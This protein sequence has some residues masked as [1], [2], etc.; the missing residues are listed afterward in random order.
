MTKCP[1]TS[2]DLSGE[3]AELRRRVAELESLGKD[4]VD[5]EVKYRAMIEAFD[6]LIYICSQDYRIEF[7]NAHFIRR[8]GHD[9]TGELCYKALHNLDSVCSWCVNERV[10]KGETV[11]WEVQSP[12]DNR[13]F[14]VVNTPIYHADGRI[15]KQAMIQD[16]TERKLAEQELRE[17]RDHLAEL[18]KA[19]TA[20]LSFAKEEAEA[21]NR[22][23]SEFLANMS[24]ELRTPLNAIMGY[25]QILGM[26][27]NLTASQRDQ[28]SIIRSS[29]EQLLSLISDILDLSR[30]EAQKVEVEGKE[31][32]LLELI[33]AVLGT[34]RLRA[35]KKKLSL[36]Y[37]PLS[38][39]PRIVKGD[40]KKIRQILLNLLDNAVKYTETGGVTLRVFCSGLPLPVQEATHQD[41]ERVGPSEYG[42]PSVALREPGPARFT[43]QV[44]D[45]GIGI[46]KEKMEQIFEP[47]IQGKSDGRAVEGIGLGLAICRRLVDL[48][49]QRLSVESEPGRG[50]TFTVTLDLEVVERVKEPVRVPERAIIGYAGVSRRILVV[51]DNA[52]NLSMLVSALESLGFEVHSAQSGEQALEMAKE[53]KPD[54]M[55]LDFLMP[56]TDGR[57]VLRRIKAQDS[58]KDIKVIGI[59]AAVA[60]GHGAETFAAACDDF[61]SKPVEFRE[62]LEKMRRHLQIE[63]IEEGAEA[64]AIDASTR[65]PAT[66]ENKTP[67]LPPRSVLETLVE[68]VDLGDFAGIEETLE[69]LFLMDS[70]YAD[71][72][73]TIRE[74]AARFDDDA[75]LDYIESQR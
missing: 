17:H 41:L 64:A 36:T 63:W 44:S 35:V 10:F 31:F 50:T 33:D 26:E 19:G 21:A 55:L 70:G 34:T 53:L 56:R 42:P 52:A 60:D 9:G 25:A 67:L 39:L 54:L 57:E 66:D 51:D 2:D 75:I 22:A 24:H 46:Q 65:P 71:F 58:H 28:I 69:K 37:E 72:C 45:T 73:A 29:G 16:I 8:T 47:F 74:Y 23:K 43:F 4:L 38:V 62:L 48:M 30:I 11:R 59:S 5:S 68:K 3:V 40:S 1:K 7:M 14:Y 13:W 6:G 15:S 61:V 49:G 12:K 32:D 18:V 20:E 27:E